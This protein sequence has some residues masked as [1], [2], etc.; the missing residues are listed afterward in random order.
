MKRADNLNIKGSCFLQQAL[1]HDTELTYNTEI[2]SSCLA[3]PFFFHIKSAE[4]TETVSGEQYLIC[5]II[6]HHN[7]RPVYH[8]SENKCQIVFSCGKGL[9]VFYDYFSVGEICAEELL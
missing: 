2:I 1:Y 9:S 6:S 8:R 5:G 3:G 7:F 4:L